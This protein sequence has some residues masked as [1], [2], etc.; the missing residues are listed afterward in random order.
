MVLF[1]VE[2]AKCS[3]PIAC[4]VGALARVFFVFFTKEEGEGEVQ[5]RSLNP[6]PEKKKRRRDESQ[7]ESETFVVDFVVCL[8][9]LGLSTS[10]KDT[11]RMATFYIII[12]SYGPT[13]SSSSSIK[14]D[15]RDRRIQRS[16]PR[17]SLP[18]LLLA[19]PPLLD[20]DDFDDFD[21]FD[22]VDDECDDDEKKVLPVWRL[23]TTT[24]EK[25]DAID[26]STAGTKK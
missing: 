8:F 12:R 13:P 2:C 24:E 25:R 15:K 10:S 20:D 14:K 3:F 6:F 19:D 21:D 9:F 5:K 16:F 1:C 17:H 22:D 4:V 11:N 23:Q 18:R 7:K 26:L